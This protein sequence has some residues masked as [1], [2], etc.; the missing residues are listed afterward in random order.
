MTALD[1]VHAPR[2]NTAYLNAQ[3]NIRP[4]IPDHPDIFA[5]WQRR[6]AA[7][8]A[9]SKTVCD[10]AYGAHPDE[11]LDLFP[12][13]QPNAPLLVFIHGGFWRALGKSDFSWVAPPFNAAG[14]A[15]AVLH[16]TLAPLATLEDIVRQMLGA[17]AWLWRHA[18]RLGFDRKRMVV[19]G[20]SAG[21]HLGAM[22]LA[23]LWQDHA[24]DLPDHIYQGATLISGV[25]DL[26]PIMRADFLNVD[27]R[28]TPQRVA[29]LSP[30]FMR[31]RVPVPVL[32]A[33]GEHESDEFKRQNRDFIAH[34]QALHRADIAAPGDNHLTVC[35]R[36][37]D[38]DHALFARTV[39]LCRARG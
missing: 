31:P 39:E 30:L 11:R 16:H 29:A 7:V 34:W 9:D 4:G 10:L 19:A 1:R 25:Y 35:E 28:L 12:A 33:V 8:R 23:A 22:M 13:A 26:D 21:A 6:S 14:I 5:R 15:V 17:S 3:Y 20:H 2:L 32:T 37:A 36:L 27:L 38:C 24:A 18:G